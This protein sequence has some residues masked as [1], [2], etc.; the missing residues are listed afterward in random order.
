MA[1]D[2]D[3]FKFLG[4]YIVNSGRV[5]GKRT[6]HY[7]HSLEEALQFRGGLPVKERGHVLLNVSIVPPPLESQLSQE[8]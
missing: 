7:F 6:P 3:G 5:G 4:T 1:K 8:N 2:K